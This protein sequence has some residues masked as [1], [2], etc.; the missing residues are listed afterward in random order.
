MKNSLYILILACSCVWFFNFVPV[1]AQTEYELLAPVPELSQNQN[2]SPCIKDGKPCATTA[3]YLP[4]LY[5]LMIMATTGLAVLLLIFAGIKYMSTDAFSEKGEAKGMISNVLWG[6]LLVMSGWIILNTVNP[7]LLKFDLKLEKI[8][9]RENK[10]PPGAQTT[11]GSG[12]C[13]NCVNLGVPGKPPGSGCNTT[14]FCQISA[15]LNTRLVALNHLSPLYVTESYPPTVQHEDPCHASGTCVD[16][17]ISSNTAQNVSN[18][19]QNARSVGLNAVFE[20]TSQT[21]YI[22]LTRGGVPATNIM[23]NPNA[24]GEHFHIK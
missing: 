6:L 3:T 10:N 20:V 7:K 14:G 11:P 12:S 23:I 21:R 2:G 16:A 15:P 8:Q 1:T 24:R 19:I 18:F 17:T 22:E 5:K 9:I 4:G 13:T